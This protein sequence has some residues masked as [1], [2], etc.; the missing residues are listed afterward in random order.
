MRKTCKYKLIPTPEQARALEV[1]LSRGHTLY[2]V[3]LEQRRTWWQRGQ[4]IGATYSRHANELPDLKA[5]CPEYSE[6]HSHVVQ[7]VLRR[8][9]TT[10]QAFFHRVQDAET[11]GSP[12]FQGKGRYTRF[13][14][15]QYGNGAVL[16]GGLLSRSKIGRIP[17]RLHRPLG[18]T[19]KTVTLSRE[20]D[21]WSAWICCAEVPTEP[22]PLT[23]NETGIDVGWKVFLVRADGEYGEHPRHHR[24]AEKGVKKA[25]R[26]VSRRTN[27]SKRWWN[28]VGQ[29]AKQHQQVKRQRG[30]FHHKTALCLVR[31]YE[32]ISLEDLQ[33]RN[34]SRRPTVK[35]DGNGGYEHNGAA[36]K[37]GRNKS[38]NDV[39]WYSFRRILTCKAA[40]AG[41]RVAALPPAV[42]T[43]ECRG[44][45]A[46]IFKR[47]S[48]RTQVCT[49]CGLILDRDEHAARTML[50]S[51][52][53]GPSGGT[54]ARWGERS[55]RSPAL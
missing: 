38:I 55:L 40:W 13:I 41:K 53:A 54:V 35:Q 1:V 52:R 2:N 8:G 17:I 28:A 37:A 3:A 11:P 39:G 45:G 21:G 49:T 5:A 22:L 33:L 15:P 51:G 6:V 36:R 16:D 20:A 18:G 31:Q 27:G 47:L 23:G 48:V 32:V 7:D 42:T 34:L 4:G 12:R 19:P 10:Y 9:D 46:R 50:A 26:C 25:Q 14:S 30:D 24:N 43:Q 44:C 29:R